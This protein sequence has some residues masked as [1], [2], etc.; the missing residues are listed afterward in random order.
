MV[1]SKTKG[2]LWFV[3][4]LACWLYYTLWI[5][6]SPFID[7]TLSFQKYFPDRKWGIGL[8]ILLGL[9]F[10]TVA[11]TLTGLALISDSNIY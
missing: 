2:T 10:L 4:V 7:Q 1:E 8:P 3:T 11:M 9:A 6:I 5:M